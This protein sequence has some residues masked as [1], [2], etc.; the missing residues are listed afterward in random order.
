MRFSLGTAILVSA[1]LALS[2]RMQGADSEP[3]QVGLKLVAEG[4]TSPLTYAPLPDGSAFLVDQVGLVRWFDAQGALTATPVFD[5]RPRLSPVNNGAFDERGLLDLVLH[6]KFSENQRVYITY[7]A[8]KSASTP[9]DWDCVLRLSEF[10][11]MPGATPTLD[12]SSERVLLDIS[13]PFNN[14]NGARLA[15]GPDGF[16]YMS[17]G[18]GG[19]ANDDGKRPS[20][21]N[22][23][24]LWAY[25]GKILRLDV[26]TAK[27][28]KLYGIPKDNPLADGKYGLPEIYAYGVRNCWGLSFDRVGGDFYAA[29]VG[30]D[31]YEEVNIIV[32]GGNYGWNKREGFHPFDPKTP[33]NTPEPG[34]TKGARGE[35]FIDPILEYPHPSVRKGAAAFGTSITG[36]FVYR[37]KAVPALVGNYVFADWS[38]NWGLPQGVLL[39]GK[40]PQN[41]GRWEVEPIRVA[42]TEKFSAYITGMGQGADGELFVLTNGSNSLIPGKGRVWKLVPAP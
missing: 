22:G 25:L 32:K 39:Q 34:V 42:N 31:L 5:I 37:G 14:H 20:T 3:V 40:R 16:L 30:Q 35:S 7:T 41:G 9:A 33:K 11:V 13:K 21:G 8:P 29:D 12:P 6:P 38:Q 4:L 18:D 17:V 1:T 27:E 36:G 24:N 10:K 2:G 19:A 28:G 23:Q 15:F 26:D